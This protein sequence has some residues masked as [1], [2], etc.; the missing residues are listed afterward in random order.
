[1]L[2]SVWNN[3]VVGCGKTSNKRKHVVH[4]KK[5]TLFQPPAEPKT[6]KIC[7]YLRSGSNTNKS[8]SVTQL[9]FILNLNPLKID[10]KF[11]S[12]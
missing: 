10:K 9:L 6:K 12:K 11:G 3:I 7:I 8:R 1:M 2:S 5:E 4:V